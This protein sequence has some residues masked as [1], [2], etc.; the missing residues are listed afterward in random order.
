MVVYTQFLRCPKSVVMEQLGELGTGTIPEKSMITRDTVSRMEKRDE[1]LKRASMRDD[2]LASLLEALNSNP[3]F[4]SMWFCGSRID[5]ANCLGS[6]EF[7]W[8][9]SALPGDYKK[10]GMPKYHPHQVEIIISIRGRI[11]VE[12]YAPGNGL[13]E[14]VL[15]PGARSHIEI[16]NCM[17]H[18]IKNIEERPHESAF[19]YVKTNV[20]REPQDIGVKGISG[21]PCRGCAHHMRPA[22][23]LMFQSYL[24]SG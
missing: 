7:G 19:F 15:E 14:N 12:T 21:E 4:S 20:G 24:R 8:G 18:R 16:T 9:I 13:K 11:C 10:A 1:L 23:C 17:C 5:H 22:E 2:S 6:E 3:E